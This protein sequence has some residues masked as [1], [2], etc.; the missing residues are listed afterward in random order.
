MY[1]QETENLNKKIL[2]ILLSVFLVQYIYS[3]D[4]KDLNQLI[5]ASLRFIWPEL[6]SSELMEFVNVGL[7]LHHTII[8]NIVSPGIYFDLGLGFD[9]MGIFSDKEFD[10]EKEK[11]TEFNQVG[12]NFGC[13]F[14]NLIEIDIVDINMFIGYNLIIGQLDKRAD[15]IIHNPIAGASVVIKFIGFEYAYYIPTKY[16]NNITFHHISIVFH[17]T[18]K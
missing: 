8:P 15:I 2:C 12:L 3:D 6:P 1:R 13:R 18:D 5:D 10:V 4:K 17:F 9:W 11:N 7:G 16:S 14:Y